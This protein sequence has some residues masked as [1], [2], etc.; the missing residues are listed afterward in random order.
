MTEKTI[1]EAVNTMVPGPIKEA[2]QGGVGVKR[3]HMGVSVDGIL[4]ADD[5]Q[6][7]GTLIKDGVELNSQQAREF[8]RQQKANGIE[9]ICGC[10]NT[11]EK[12]YCKGHDLT[13]SEALK[14][15]KAKASHALS[16]AATSTIDSIGVML[17]ANAMIERLGKASNEGRSG[18]ETAA[19][20]DLE[21]AAMAM[22]SIRSGRYVSAA[23]F[24]MMLFCR[25][26]EPQAMAIAASPRIVLDGTQLLQILAHC[27]PDRFSY[28]ELLGNTINVVEFNE[29]AASWLEHTAPHIA[30]Q[31]CMELDPPIVVHPFTTDELAEER[32]IENLIPAGF[33]ITQAWMV[34]KEFTGSDIEDLPGGKHSS[35][36]NGSGITLHAVTKAV[37]QCRGLKRED[38]EEI[39][40][41]AIMAMGDKQGAPWP[42]FHELG[43]ND[44]TFWRAISAVVAA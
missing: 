43:D 36:G 19:V 34:T 38:P 18:W 23:N 3:R 20:S 28:H 25:G 44:R 4:A 15:A 24:L 41:L 9:V 35:S 27:S 13:V 2:L 32:A 22:N 12:G 14:D 17:F 31:D 16:R 11:D 10:G 6:I 39:Y 33:L 8:A 37:N 7:H 30:A 21:L 26:A 42:M 40:T 1:S 5:H 29:V